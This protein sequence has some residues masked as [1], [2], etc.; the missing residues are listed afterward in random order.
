MAYF[1]Q[2]GALVTLVV[3]A[4]TIPDLSWLHEEVKTG[5]ARAGIVGLWLH[6]HPSAGRRVFL[7]HEWKLVWGQ[8]EA[9]SPDGFVYGPVSFQQQITDLHLQAL[10]ASADF[11]AP[12]AGSVV[13]DLY[14]GS[15]RSVKKWTE[16]GA[17][18]TGVELSGEA[19][20]TAS[21]NV[22]GAVFL[23]GK[24]SERIPQL[25]Q[26][27]N[28]K[29]P[30]KERLLYAN[31]PRTGLEENVLYWISGSCRPS[32]M[33]Y[34]SCSP[35]TLARDLDHLEKKSYRTVAVTPFDFF[36]FTRHIECLALLERHYS[37]Q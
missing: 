17:G 8:T 36:P 22:P 7:K 20:A 13:V 2:S 30:D 28:E 15:G 12:S 4:K 6:L 31:P 16:T 25:E 26:I 35:G 23:R 24:C 27:V 34:L 32:R 1:V 9:I 10:A 3:K 37:A 11:L 14:S 21:R 29:Y 19:V 5:L 33:G 18:V